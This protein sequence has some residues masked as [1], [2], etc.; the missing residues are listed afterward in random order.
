MPRVKAISDDAVLDAALEL[1]MEN[2]LDRFTLPAVGQATGLAPSTLLQRFQSKQLL[3]ERALLRATERLERAVLALP[4]S[5][6]S[7]KDLVDWLVKLAEPVGTRERIAASFSLLRD[8]LTS[9]G[10]HALAQRHM[11]AIR[12]G[13]EGKLEQIG[14]DAPRAQAS[15]FEAHWHG[16]VIQWALSGTGTLTSWMRRGLRELLDVLCPKAR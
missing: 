7:R 14:S 12:R 8:D 11:R 1:L 4:D 3:I 13:I 10:R 6:D 15:L 16:L 2:G 9:P 5:G